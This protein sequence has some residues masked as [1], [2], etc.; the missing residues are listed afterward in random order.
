MA[1]GYWAKSSIV[2]RLTGIPYRQN[3]MVMNARNGR[4]L[5][6]GECAGSLGMTESTFLNLLLPKDGKEPELR[7]EIWEDEKGLLSQHMRY[8]RATAGKE[9]EGENLQ[10]N[11]LCYNRMMVRQ[12]CSTMKTEELRLTVKAVLK[13]SDRKK[14]LIVGKTEDICS[15]YHWDSRKKRQGE[16]ERKRQVCSK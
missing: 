6:R 11:M 1:K 12:W 13:I 2:K 16:E 10:R 8:V 5:V 4:I 14:I 3:D 9:K 7:M 15:H